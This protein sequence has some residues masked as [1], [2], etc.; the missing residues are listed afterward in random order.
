LHFFRAVRSV[1]G[2]ALD[3]HRRE[4]VVTSAQVRDQVGQQ[5]LVGARFPQVVMRVDDRL[6]RIYDV[7]GQLRQPLRA[8]A[9]MMKWLAFR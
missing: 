6:G 4:D 9:W 1:F 7:L 8:N 2:S 5:I 3:E